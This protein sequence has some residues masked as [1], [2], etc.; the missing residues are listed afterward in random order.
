MR[1]LPLAV[2]FL[3]AGCAGNLADY[4]GPRASI[5]APELPRYG[6]DSRQTECISERLGASLSPLQLRLFARSAGALRRGFFDPVRLTMRDL[7]H[8]ATTV[9]E[10][11]SLELI[12]AAAACGAA[13]ELAVRRE[14]PDVVADAESPP[15]SAQSR[16]PVWLN[17]GAAPTGQSIAIDA[18]TIEQEG[19]RRT[20]W[21]RLTD[22]APAEPTG[23]SYLLS[24]DCAARTINPRARK[25]VD[26]TGAVVENVD[27]PDNPLPVE[28]GT[29]ME[30]AYLA[31]CT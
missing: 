24:V 3:A 21:F 1:L 20:A 22:P 14:T 11:V 4:V 17:L 27:Y 8:V 19:G 5:I 12:R 2:L 23:N 26:D 16:T 7:M 29:V 10:P 30:I 6:L 9:S 15:A 25:R 13:P 31:L 28:G 18:S